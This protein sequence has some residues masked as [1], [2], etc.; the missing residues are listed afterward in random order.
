MNVGNGDG[1]TLRDRQAEA[2]RQA[3]VDAFLELAHQANSVSIS[4]PAVARRAGVSVRTLYRY[5]ATKDELQTAV[6]SRSAERA[7]ATMTDPTLDRSTVARYMTGLWASFADDLPAVVAEL[8]TPVGRQLRAARL[9][10]SRVTTARLAPE[11]AGDPEAVDLLVA[12]LSSSMFLE[13]VGRMAYRPERAAALATYL[14]ELVAADVAIN[15]PLADR[16]LP[17]RPLPARTEQSSTDH[18][19]Q[20]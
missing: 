19:I 18:D 8:A 11:V 20:S 9:A 17:N 15:G 10:D 12:V 3:I 7:Q 14:G 16:A 5:F 4:M 13:L 6:A 2:T 1:G